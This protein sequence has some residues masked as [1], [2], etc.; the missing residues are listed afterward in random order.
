MSLSGNA[1]ILNRPAARN[2]N[3]APAKSRK[4]QT[5]AMGASRPVVFVFMLATVLVA[6]CAS[7]RLP[8]E[9]AAR[10]Q[11]QQVGRKL[12]LPTGQP[13]LP[14]LRPDS[15]PADFVLYATLNH[16]AVAAAY[17]DWLAAVEAI[18]PARALPDP[19][20]TFEADIA[21]TL[22]TFMPGVMFDLMS[23]GKRAAMG[24]EAAATSQVA[25][26][27]Y[28]AAVMG[29]A[30]DTRKAWIELAYLDE[31]VRLKA[32]ALDALDQARALAEAGYATGRGMGTLENQSRLANADA[33][34]RTELATLGDRRSALRARFKSSL[35]LTSADPDPAWPN[36]ALTVTVL[37]PAE[38]LWQRI[39]ADNPG[40]AQM[41]AM[42]DMSLAGVAVARKS[43]TP[44]FTVG[45]MADLK[46]DP[47][48]VRPTASATLPIW[49]DK[50][51]AT[52]AAARAKHD[53][54]VA[55]V[56]AEQLNLAAE[57][58]QMLYMVR[59][60]DRMIAYIDD[61]ALPIYE[62]TVAT[63]EAGYQSGMTEP[64]MIPETRFMALDMRLERANALRER[65]SAVT[66]L[67]LMIATIAP[68][69]APLAAGQP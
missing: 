47:L 13:S 61:T 37:P 11:A 38:E 20:L 42:V 52:V 36:A 57:L 67:L 1:E 44:D 29:A 41:R 25:Y 24:R 21:D 18:T 22:M 33:K 4:N 26:R 32:G 17:F 60:A 14:E 6:G 51:A 65:E 15:P 23:S 7:T 56:N 39:Q 35:G 69:G 3:S 59:E 43:G 34:A 66:D 5:A 58:A 48:M 10:H 28:V 8:A 55:R 46:A 19:Q 63:V 31:A 12:R 45:L 30:A 40:L 16:P 62:R 68:S 64:A 27:A 9:T 53:A 2:T 49:R 54:A 50:I